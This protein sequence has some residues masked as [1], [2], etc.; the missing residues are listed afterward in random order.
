MLAELIAAATARQVQVAAARARELSVALALEAAA[1]A[2]EG[3]AGDALRRAQR[4]QTAMA[5]LLVA[6]AG[7]I[8]ASM[9]SRLTAA[10]EGLRWN[11]VGNS[12]ERSTPT[13]PRPL[14]S[15]AI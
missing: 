11:S 6:V 14:R 4:R 9:A 15:V 12:R 2:S 13:L 3:H 1:A 8:D 7:G 10:G 5:G